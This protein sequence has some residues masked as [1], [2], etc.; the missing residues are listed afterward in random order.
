MTGPAAET[1]MLGYSKF[2]QQTS[3]IHQRLWSRAFITVDQATGKWV[4]YV[5]A[6]ASAGAVPT[7]RAQ[8]RGH[9]GQRRADYRGRAEPLTRP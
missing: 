1:G 6:Q 4:A 8:H 3:G 5:N 2:D 9:G 7:G